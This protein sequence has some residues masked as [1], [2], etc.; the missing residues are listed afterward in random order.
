GLGLERHI[1]SVGFTPEAGYNREWDTGAITYLHPMGTAIEQRHGAPDV[2]LHRA[3]LQA[4][5]LSINQSACIHF[6]KQLVGLDRAG[7][8]SRLSFGDD[9]RGEA[10]AVVGAAGVHSVVLKILFGTGAPRF[11][12]GVAS[13]AIYRGAL[14]GTQVDDR[15]KGGGP[16]RHI[17]SYKVDPRR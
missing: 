4:A 6:A 1:C 12:G 10:E 17:V 8:G 11:T 2:S 15:V 14:L 13:R 7:G 5:L 9:G 3:A 16:D